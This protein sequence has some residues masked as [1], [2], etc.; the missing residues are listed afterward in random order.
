M[1]TDRFFDGNADNNA[2]NG[3]DTYGK[4]NAGLYHGGDFAGVTQ[5]LDYLKDL[6]EMVSPK[7]N[8]GEYHL[9][10][11]DCRQYFRRYSRWGGQGRCALQCRVSWLLGK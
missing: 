9:D 3:A 2:A 6:G 4:D 8:R 10:Y 11:A 7:H 5:K 1:V